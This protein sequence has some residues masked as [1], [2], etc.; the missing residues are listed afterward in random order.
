MILIEY[1]VID[2]VTYRNLNGA[3]LRNVQELYPVS[4]LHLALSAAPEHKYILFLS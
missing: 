4:D 3:I 2:V 1:L